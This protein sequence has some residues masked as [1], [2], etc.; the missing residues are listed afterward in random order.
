MIDEFNK[1]CHG[2]WENTADFVSYRF[3]DDCTLSLQPSKQGIDWRRNFDIFPVVRR[4]GCRDI[5][6]PCGFARAWDSLLPIISA[7]RFYGVRGYSHG[8]ALAAY[9]SAAF[10]IPAVVFGCPHY[11]FGADEYFED[12]THYDAPRDIVT[13]ICWPYGRGENVVQLPKG[14]TRSFSG[15]TPTEYREGLQ[16]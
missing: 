10:G 13:K 2:P 9:V 3:E 7:R 12:V 6:I 4:I 11:E 8:A 16:I 1:C 15:H 5:T 14:Q